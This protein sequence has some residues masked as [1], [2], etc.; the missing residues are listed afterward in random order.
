M[1]GSASHA[2]GCRAQR[3]SGASSGGGPGSSDASRCRWPGRRRRHSIAA[4]VRQLS[5]TRQGGATALVPRGRH[6]GAQPNRPPPICIFS[7]LYIS[8]YCGGNR[9]RRSRERAG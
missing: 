2:P 5:P 9:G 4:S 7:L 1:A 8:Q 6:E 3:A